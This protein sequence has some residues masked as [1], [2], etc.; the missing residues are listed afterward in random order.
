[1][2]YA[3]TEEEVKA[4]RPEWITDKALAAEVI[5]SKAVLRKL[6]N[7]AMNTHVAGIDFWNMGKRLQTEYPGKI[8][9]KTELEVAAGY[10]YWLRKGEVE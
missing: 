2:S 4:N 10:W 6:V 3:D 1:M 9:Y 8:P 5:P 7:T